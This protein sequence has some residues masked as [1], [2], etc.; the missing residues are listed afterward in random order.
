MTAPDIPPQIA[1]ARPEMTTAIMA[2]TCIDEVVLRDLV[3]GFYGNVRRDPVLGPIFAAGIVDWG[4]HLERM[5]A[6]WSPV[7]LMT[8]RYHGAPYRRTPRFRPDWRILSA[9][10][11]C[12]ARRRAKPACPR[13]P[14]T[15][16][17]GP[18]ASH[19]RSS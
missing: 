9:G 7:A 4:P 3:H 6:F 12:S 17:N 15:S 19:A 11:R 5:V 18:N 1:S 8:G 14:R 16:S 2:G 13:V 10:W